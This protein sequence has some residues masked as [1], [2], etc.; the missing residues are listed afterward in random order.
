MKQKKIWMYMSIGLIL[1]IAIFC[2]F[3]FTKGERV[4]SV[5]GQPIYK[6]QLYDML[7]T[8]YGAEAIDSLITDIIVEEEV[9]KENISVSQED[10]DEEMT[11]YTESYGGEESFNELLA[12]SGIERTTI[13]QDIETF[14]AIKKLLE[15]RISITEEELTAYF[16]EN[17]EFYGEEEQVHAKHILVEDEATAKEVKDKLLAGE[18]FSDLALE[19]STDEANRESGGD[20]GFFGRGQ[21]VQEFE[22]VAFTLDIGVISDPVSTEF[23]YHIITVEEKTAAKEAN[24]QDVKEEIESTLF[25]Q[26]VE[27]E[28]MT[29]L[30]EKFAEYE[31]EYF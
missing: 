18:D 13:E 4:A 6:D 3:Y 19:Y 10:L 17:K 16:E 21:M 28:Y 5:N 23:G 1:I 26:K 20:L 7:V 8:Q 25:E 22:D 27:T 11:V 31:I 24:F 29:W 30:N 2:T 9:K 15:P 12:S 14:L